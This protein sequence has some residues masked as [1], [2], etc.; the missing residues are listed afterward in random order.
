[1]HES[2]KEYSFFSRPI[3]SSVWIISTFPFFPSTILQSFKPIYL[4]HSRSQRVHLVS[5]PLVLLFCLAFSFYK[6]NL[7]LCP[8]S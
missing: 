1:M 8:M 4:N 6:S 5:F 7:F 2:E 3:C